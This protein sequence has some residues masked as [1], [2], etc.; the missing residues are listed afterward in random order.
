MSPRDVV[1]NLKSSTLWISLMI[2]LLT[3]GLIVEGMTSGLPYETWQFPRLIFMVLVSLLVIEII[4]E[5]R[6]LVVSDHEGAE[7]IIINKNVLK[8]LLLII[9]YVFL[10]NIIGFF[11]TSALFMAACLFITGYKHRVKMCLF[12]VLVLVGIYVVFIEYLNIPLPS[13]ILF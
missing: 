9:L 11:I 5:I 2:L 3:V 1:A 8:V 12:T 10:L 7:T 4:S 6:K 13:G